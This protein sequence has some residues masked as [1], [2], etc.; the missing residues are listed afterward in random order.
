MDSLPPVLI[1]LA[2]AAVYGVSNIFARLSLQIIHPLVVALI[3]TFVNLLVA[4]PIGFSI[5]P[6]ADYRWE[7]IVS[8]ILMGLFGFAGLRLLFA[9][10]IRLLGVSRHAPIA[11]IYPIFTIFVGVFIFGESPNTALWIGTALI[12]VGIVWVAVGSEGD[13]WQ[14]KYL[15]LP[16]LQAIL[17]TIGAM[18]R[19]L[20][21][22]HMN[23][24]LFAIAVGGVSGCIALLGYF[25]INRRD[26]TIWKYDRN[27]LIFAVALGLTNLLAQYLYTHALAR[28]D[29]SFII[30]IISTAPIFT[31]F[32]TWAFLSRVERV[33]PKIFLGGSLTVAG[34][35]CLIIFR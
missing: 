11:G 28:G 10:G 27:G 26:E 17:R 3:F 32:F 6:V 31:L 2:S 33:G 34:T 24:P 22:I 21:L 5:V 12:V 7:A 13:I 29:I 9:I 8:F 18:F 30:P 19:K 16:I 1:A 25:W 20:G 4:G 23:H 15:V 14:R 35:V